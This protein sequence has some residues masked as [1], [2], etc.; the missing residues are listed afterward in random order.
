MGATA[1]DSL[2]MR[3]ARRRMPKRADVSDHSLL[4]A[5]VTQALLT[6]FIIVMKMVDGPA[7]ADLQL[8][9]IPHPQLAKRTS[10]ARCI[11]AVVRR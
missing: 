9:H 8:R 1:L 3:H 10:A 2:L 5:A 7:L 11:H 6:S 4:V